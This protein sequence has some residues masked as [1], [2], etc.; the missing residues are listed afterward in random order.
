[1]VKVIKSIIVRKPED[2]P[3]LKHNIGIIFGKNI[4]KVEKKNGGKN[5][6]NPR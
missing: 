3:K 1:M 2:L 5:D 4:R 6:K